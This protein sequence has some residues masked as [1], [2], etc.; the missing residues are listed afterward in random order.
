VVVAE[1]ICLQLFVHPG[2]KAAVDCEKSTTLSGGI[3]VP[4][5]LEGQP[6]VQLHRHLVLRPLV[7]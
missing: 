7:E 1:T 5:F 2:A 3:V 4:R 6:T